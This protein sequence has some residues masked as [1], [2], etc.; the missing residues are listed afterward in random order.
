MTLPVSVGAVQPVTIPA[1]GYREESFQHVVVFKRKHWLKKVTVDGV[2][3]F[4]PANKALLLP[5]FRIPRRSHLYKRF[6]SLRNQQWLTRSSNFRHR[7]QA[8]GFEL[9]DC[10]ASLSLGDRH[11][12][13]WLFLIGGFRHIWSPTR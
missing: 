13:Y 6:S 2:F 11:F 10:H 7:T 4:E 5:L 3:P 1:R 8:F 12:G 9:A